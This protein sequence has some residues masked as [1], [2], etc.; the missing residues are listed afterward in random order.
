MVAAAASA[1]AQPIVDANDHAYGPEVA[2]EASVYGN[3]VEPGTIRNARGS[4]CY[5]GVV[6]CVLVA[7][8]PYPEPA[9]AFRIRIYPDGVYAVAEIGRLRG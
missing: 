7:H 6:S 4:S 5:I 3:P 1:R 8:S 2:R 9:T